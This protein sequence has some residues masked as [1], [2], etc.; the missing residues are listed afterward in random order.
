[1]S[2]NLFS[3]KN[4]VVAITGGA[5]GIGKAIAIAAIIKGAKV[6]ISDINEEDL[7]EVKMNMIF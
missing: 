4:K 1:M 7:K 6:S 5:N 3:W 2:D